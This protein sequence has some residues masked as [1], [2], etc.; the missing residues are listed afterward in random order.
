MSVQVLMPKCETSLEVYKQID[1][2]LEDGDI[3][4]AVALFESLAEDFERGVRTR[5]REAIDRGIPA[6]LSTF[7]AKS[8]G[9]YLHN[10]LVAAGAFDLQH[11]TCTRWDL[12]RAYLIPNRLRLF[13]QGGAVNHTHM[14]AGAWNTRV[15]HENGV[16]RFW[17]HARDPRQAAL[18]AYWHGR[19]YGHGVDETVV[20]RR[21]SEEAQTKKARMRAVGGTSDILDLPMDAQIRE[22]FSW[23]NSWINEWI[24]YL[25][26]LRFDVLLTTHEQM[27]AD[28]TGFENRVLHF[29]DA[30][31]HMRGAFGSI[32]PHDRFRK[33]ATDEWRAEVLPETRDWMTT[34]MA[35]DV[36]ELL[37]WRV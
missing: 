26:I 33:G 36:T 32:L 24:A 3:L 23:R 12:E 28:P 16:S 15:M 27:V 11:H 34:Q 9:T 2:H 1:C 22:Q 14:R 8:G 35:P 21:L 7:M 20:G 10:H 13:L 31:E 25:P 30:P 4:N 5:H 19:G 17:I 18:S 37:G 29:F 6:F